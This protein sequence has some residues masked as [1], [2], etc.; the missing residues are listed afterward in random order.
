MTSDLTEQQRDE[1][2][3]AL[4]EMPG[5]YNLTDYTGEASTRLPDGSVEDIADALAPVVARMI[6][7]ACDQVKDETLDF[8]DAHRDQWIQ[9]GA[10]RITAAVG[11]ALASVDDKDG[12]EG[13]YEALSDPD[14]AL[15]RVKAEALREAADEMEAVIA[16][17]D[18]AAV[19]A[20]VPGE[21]GRAT[22]VG[23]RD[24]LYE[25]PPT[26]LRDHAVRIAR[27][28]TP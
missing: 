14:A 15:S 27:G 23:R 13:V 19:A 2:A 17:G 10:D 25:E 9:L 26:W 20:H 4:G 6:A 24:S 8:A 16:D 18:V 21:V 5:A 22:A 11:Q 1:L 28:G 7:D 12:L 3:E